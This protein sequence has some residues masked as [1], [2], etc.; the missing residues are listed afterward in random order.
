MDPQVIHIDFEPTFSDH[1]SKDMIHECLKSRRS[2]AEAK[3]HYGG[4]KE[5]ERS[6]ECRFPLVFLPDANVVIAPSNIELGEQCG[7]LHI[8][9]QL[10]DE[11]K[12]IPIVDGVGVEISIVLARSQGSVLLGHKE[13]QR[14][15]WRFR[16]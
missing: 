3:E 7:V 15:L 4:F 14:G 16:G 2:V 9:D 10:R 6:D 12:G 11:G 5:A 1:V 13:K 8:I